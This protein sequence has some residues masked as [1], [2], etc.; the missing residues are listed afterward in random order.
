MADIG[1][2]LRDHIQLQDRR[3]VTVDIGTETVDLYSGPIRGIDIEQISKYHP[4]FAERPTVEASVRMIVVMVEDADGN[5]MFD[6]GHI[7]SLMRMPLEWVAQVRDGLWPNE[8][9]DFSDEAV[10]NEEK[11]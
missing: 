11:N 9:V 3:K 10:E 2:L 1:K 7:P 6:V 8:D 4:D 5:K